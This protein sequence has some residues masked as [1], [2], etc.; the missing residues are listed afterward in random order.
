MIWSAGFVRLKLQQSTVLAHEE[1]HEGEDGKEGEEGAGR[2]RRGREESVQ[3]AAGARLR[4]RLRRGC[5]RERDG[6]RRSRE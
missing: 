3:G 5:A 1:P 4:V 6:V 2:R